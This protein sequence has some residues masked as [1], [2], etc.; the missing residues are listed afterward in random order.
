MMFTPPQTAASLSHT[1]LRCSFPRASPRVAS[2]N[3]VVSF[4]YVQCSV[5]TRSDLRMGC[6]TSRVCALLARHRFTV[7]P[8][9]GRREEV[10]RFTLHL[11]VRLLL[12]RR[13]AKLRR[14]CG[15]RDT[16]DRPAV[17]ARPGTA[18]GQLSRRP[19]SFGRSEIVVSLRQVEQGTC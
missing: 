1:G 19:G 18:R 15:G 8:G 6:S 17:T 4:C 7:S 10:E 11:I 9:V 16:T 5:R 12:R 14:S 3:R 13:H 2:R